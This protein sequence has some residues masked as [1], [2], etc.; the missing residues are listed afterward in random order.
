MRIA[1]GIILLLVATLL[2]ATLVTRIEMLQGNA[3][4]VLMTLMALLL[5]PGNKPDWKWGI[6]A[7]L[8]VGFASALP[9]WVFLAGYIA[10]AGICQLLHK[11]IWQVTL[12][13]L[14]TATLLGTLVI[15]LITL[16]YLWFSANPLGL[17][18]AF[19]LVTLPSM[20]LNLILVFPVYAFVGEL[21]KLLIP[22]EEPA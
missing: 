11:R 22:T 2:Q 6:P 17:A 9:Y 8:M 18:E 15:H 19:N 21:S 1:L 7:G 5:I 14:V 13:T 12:L 16:T 3:D 20:L 4:L 10:A